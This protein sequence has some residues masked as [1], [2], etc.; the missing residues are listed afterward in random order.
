MFYPVGVLHIKSS[1]IILL[2]FN[3]QQNITNKSPCNR[4]DLG[5]DIPFSLPFVQ[6]FFGFVNVAG[7]LVSENMFSFYEDGSVYIGTE[8]YSGIATYHAS[9]LLIINE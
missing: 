3:I 8:G 5:I 4:T 6:H 7:K 9:G 1:E 2:W